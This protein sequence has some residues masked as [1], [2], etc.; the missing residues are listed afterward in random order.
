MNYL[1]LSLL[2]LIFTAGPV[3]ADEET[4]AETTNTIGNTLNQEI[5]TNEMQDL[6]ID[7]K[8]TEPKATKPRNKWDF[9][10]RPEDK[11]NKS[12][13]SNEKTSTDKNGYKRP[14]TKPKEKW[15][16]KDTTKTKKSLTTDK[17]KTNKFP[18]L[19]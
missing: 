5:L 1:F 17:I 19:K 11:I 15:L 13:P 18:T 2:L 8:M 10:D 4:T 12:Q 16:E 9:S 3:I 14:M 6:T 7:N